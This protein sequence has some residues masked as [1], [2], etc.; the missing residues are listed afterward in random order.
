MKRGHI[1]MRTCLVCNRK[2]PKHALLRLALRG[3]D[4]AADPTQ[5]MD[6]RGAY[7]CPKPD[8]LHHLRF[9]KRMQR[10]FRGKARGLSQQDI[11]QWSSDAER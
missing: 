7:V 5:S 11:Q 3:P 10:A 9:D 6:G 1:A 4:I 2:S 8:C